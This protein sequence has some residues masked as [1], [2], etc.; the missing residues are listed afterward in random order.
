M[1]AEYI[2]VPVPALHPFAVLVRDNLLGVTV[3]VLVNA[4]TAALAEQAVTRTPGFSP[5]A[6]IE[7]TLQVGP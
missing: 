2:V 1:F 3:E 7:E 4:P 6:T 5:Y